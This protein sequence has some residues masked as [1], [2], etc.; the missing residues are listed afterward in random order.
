M[1]TRAPIGSYVKP[2]EYSSNIL[3]PNTV[4]N[5][6]FISLHFC[7]LNFEPERHIL[8]VVFV[9]FVNVCIIFFV[10]HNVTDIVFF[11]LRI[12]VSHLIKV[13]FSNCDMYVNMWRTYRTETNKCI[14]HHFGLSFLP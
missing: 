3:L 6:F 12:Q 8:F 14:L 4:T 13:I 9:I 11:V 1:Y 10:N 5:F 2:C 7:V